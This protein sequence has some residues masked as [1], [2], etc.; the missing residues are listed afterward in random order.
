MPFLNGTGHYHAEIS[1]YNSLKG[2]RHSAMELKQTQEA[3]SK[4]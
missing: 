3:D 2:G 4:L 1:A